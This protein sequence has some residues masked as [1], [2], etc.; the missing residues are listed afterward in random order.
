MSDN[1]SDEITAEAG[2]VTEFILGLMKERTPEKAES[3]Q[4]VVDA[5]RI[6]FYLNE[7]EER[8][9]FNSNSTSGVINIGLNGTARLMAHS[10]AYL[11]ANFAFIE[12]MRS[13]AEHVDIPADYDRRIQAANELLTWAVTKDVKCK[14]PKHAQS[15]LPDYLPDDL[16][17]LLE[18]CLTG[19]HQ[20]RAGELFANALVWILY[21]EVA[22]IQSG[23]VGCEGCE[24][25]EQE[26][27]ADR[28]AADW[29]VGSDTLDAAEQWKRQVGIAT[30]LGWL[31]TPTIYLGPG[32][33]R[34]HPHAHDR[35]FQI[36]DHVTG[37]DQQDVWL[38]AQMILT[39]HVLNR[40]LEIDEGQMGENLRDNCNYLI[41]LISKLPAR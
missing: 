39:L 14:M 18:K 9:F 20:D 27:R 33:M 30:A 5:H 1:L 17:S 26:K 29:M 41:D 15:V 32:R 31:T 13:Q 28:M 12:R 22:H 40:G 2:N 36:V 8:V 6:T 19:R 24:S 34:T 7:D 21:H 4:Q 23:D 10:Y 3:L 35:F 25:I 37:P 16:V 38:F 11:S